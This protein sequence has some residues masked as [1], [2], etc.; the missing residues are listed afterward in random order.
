MIPAIALEDWT[1]TVGWA[2]PDQLEQDLTL[3]RLIVEIANDLWLALTRLAIPPD[4][5]LTCFAP[6]R[7]EKY[8]GTLA[9]ANL[10][11]KTQDEFFRRDLDAL[12]GQWPDDY[13]IDAAAVLIIE[14]LLS[15]VD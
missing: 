8:T 6:Y 3:A 15:R 12:V 14:S 13:D 9:T 7:P 10:Q 11:L 2:N 4:E 5:I 1:N